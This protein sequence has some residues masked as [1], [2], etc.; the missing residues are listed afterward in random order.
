MNVQFC[1]L[2]GRF[3]ILESVT[4]PS[5]LGMSMIHPALALGNYRENLKRLN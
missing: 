3:L 4:V 1:Q 5:P 2:T